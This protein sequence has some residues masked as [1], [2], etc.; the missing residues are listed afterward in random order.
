[1]TPTQSNTGSATQTRHFDKDGNELFPCRC[2]ETHAGD[3]GFYDWA[4]HNCFHDERLIA[5]DA[6]DGYYMC[7]A[8]GK[9][10]YLDHSHATCPKCGD[11]W[12]SASASEGDTRTYKCPN[13][14]GWD[15]PARPFPGMPGIDD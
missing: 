15:G 7:P 1:M 8:C 3:Y 14:H 4:H 10:F 9:T 2:G 11:D 13:G 5:I 12:V 6:S